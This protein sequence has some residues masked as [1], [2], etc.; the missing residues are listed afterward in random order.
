[1]ESAGS[2]SVTVVTPSAQRHSV[3]CPHSQHDWGAIGHFRRGCTGKQPGFQTS[4]RKLTSHGQRS[5]YLCTQGTP[6]C[7]TTGP[8]APRNHK[9][10][11]PGRLAG[12]ECPQPLRQV[13]PDKRTAP[14][15]PS[16]PGSPRCRRPPALRRGTSQHPPGASPSR[17][18]EECWYDASSVPGACLMVRLLTTGRTIPDRK[19]PCADSP[20]LPSCALTGTVPRPGRRPRPQRPLRADACRGRPSG[21]AIT[22]CPR[23]RRAGRSH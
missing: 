12:P 5:W 22:S 3:K 14:Q 20:R 16:N 4:F 10:P 23:G 13:P 9:P 19:P 2:R 18:R 15:C 7:I 6:E 8:G 17:H 21:R 1:M 11:R